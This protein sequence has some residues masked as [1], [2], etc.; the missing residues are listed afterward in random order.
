MSLRE[1]N[2]QPSC[3]QECMSDKYLLAV[4]MVIFLAI[5]L[6]MAASLLELVEPSVV[7]LSREKCPSGDCELLINEGNVDLLLQRTGITG[8]MTLKINRSIEI[9]ET[10]DVEAKQ[11]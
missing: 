6:L 2:H 3:L 9:E 1:L 11:K 10:E 7:A 4:N 8:M 5:G